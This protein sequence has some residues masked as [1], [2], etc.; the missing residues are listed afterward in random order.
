MLPP[1]VAGV[2]VG[3]V[4]GVAVGGGAAGAG[5]AVGVGWGVGGGGVGAARAGVVGDGV[6]VAEGGGVGAAV[7]VNCATATVVAVAFGVEVGSTPVAVS[8]AL[9]TP[10]VRQSARMPPAT[11]LAVFRIFPRV[12]MSP[13]HSPHW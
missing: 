11:A 1:P 6:A 13:P 2:E 4:G 10:Q 7:G 3:A 9:P 8:T 12:L 5:G